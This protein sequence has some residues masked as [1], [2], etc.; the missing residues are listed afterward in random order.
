LWKEGSSNEL[1]DDCFGDS[2]ILSEALRCIQV[3]LLCLQQHPIDR[4]NM[5]SVLAMLTNETVLAQPKEPGFIIKRV[6]I[7]GES[8]SE[9]VMSSSI[10][11]VTISLLDAR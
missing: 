4:P 7:E 2:Y 10:N 1:V 6:S 11:E 9:N 8:K 3:G 5:V